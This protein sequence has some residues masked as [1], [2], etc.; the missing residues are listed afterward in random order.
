[1]K[2]G[3]TREKLTV[4]KQSSHKLVQVS[5]YLVEAKNVRRSRFGYTSRIIK[6]TKEPLYSTVVRSADSEQT[7]ITSPVLT[8]YKVRVAIIEFVFRNGDRER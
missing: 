7:S 4:P 6:G 2:G 1:M 8:K 3:K 5:I